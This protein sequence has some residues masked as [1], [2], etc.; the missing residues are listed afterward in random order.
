MKIKDK[1]I[2]TIAGVIIAIIV[3]GAAAGGYIALSGNGNEEGTSGDEE[4]SGDEE[5]GE[6]GS[7]ITSASSIEFKIDLETPE[8]GKST[9]R[10]RARNLDATPDFR[11][12]TTMGGQEFSYI[13]NGSEEKGWVYSNGKWTEFTEMPGFDWDTYWNQYHS[14]YEEYSNELAE[15]WTGGDYEWSSGGYSYKLYDIEVNPS[16]SDSIFQPN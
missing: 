9:T 8:T 2:Q 7:G 11:I 4:G 6:S 5:S 12:D 15:G 14:S 16:L 1:G 10:Y 3:I 13:L